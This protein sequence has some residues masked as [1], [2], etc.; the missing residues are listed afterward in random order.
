L[1]ASEIE[2]WQLFAPKNRVRQAIFEAGRGWFLKKV[3]NFSGK[4][5]QLW[6]IPAP[7]M[8]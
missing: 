1:R 8:I 4:L 7:L 5:M 3:E 2:A 6:Y